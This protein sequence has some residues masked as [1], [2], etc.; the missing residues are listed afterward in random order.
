M[1]DNK[2]TMTEEEAFA[3][4]GEVKCDFFAYYKREF[5]FHAIAPDG[6]HITL[7]VSIKSKDAREILVYPKMTIKMSRADVTII[8]R[9]GK[10]LYEDNFWSKD[11]PNYRPTILRESDVQVA[12]VS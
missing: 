9:D 11:H 7:K 3:A 1:Y 12:E 8:V 6:A 4:Y 10:V 2:P 5:T